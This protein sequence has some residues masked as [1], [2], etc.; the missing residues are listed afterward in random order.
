MIIREAA[1]APN[2][3]IAAFAW[4]GLRKFLNVEATAQL[5]SR[6]H[7]IGKQHRR[8]VEKQARQIRYCLL[9]ARE[10]ADAAERVSL[11]TKPTLLYYSIMCLAL[12]EVLL[13]HTGNSSLDRAR[14]QH[15]HHGLDFK[16]HAMPGSRSSL[17]QAAHCLSAAP[18]VKGNGEPFGTF[19]LWHQSAREMPII[20]EQRERLGVGQSTR[21]DAVL[22]VAD[23]QLPSIPVGGIALL[24]VFRRL[25]AMLDYMNGVNIPS[26]IV[27][28]TV[29]S[30]FTRTP[31]NWSSTFSM[32]IHPASPGLVEGFLDNCRFDANAVD[33]VNYDDFA[34]GGHLTWRTDSVNPLVNFSLPHGSVLREGQVRFWLDTPPLNEFGYYYVGLFIAGNYARYYPDR[35]IADVEQHAPIALA[36]EEMIRTAEERAPLLTLS[37]FSRHYLVPEA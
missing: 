20:G 7:R 25:P 5:I 12:A 2:R 16:V 14:E 29:S 15:R 6:L 11:V 19:E 32:F 37:E 23:V 22:G 30:D 9:Q 28:A 36:I 35:W 3:E 26:A 21:L 13:K 4:A 1:R 10:Y 24:E 17:G 18:A 8:N 27:R 31:P 34:S 33:R